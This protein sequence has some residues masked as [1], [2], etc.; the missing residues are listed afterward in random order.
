MHSL[1]RCGA[2]RWLVSGVSPRE[3]SPDYYPVLLFCVGTSDITRSSLRGI[4]K[5]YRILGV[6]VRDSRVQVVFSSVLLIKGK[7]VGRTS[8]IWH[9]NKWLQDWCHS[10]GF[11]YLDHGTH[12]EKPSLL[13]SI[14]QRREKHLR[15]EA[16]QACGEGFKLKLP[17]EEILNPFHSYQCNA[18]ASNRWLQ[19]LGKDHRS[20]REYLEW[21]LVTSGVP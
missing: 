13:G 7:V 11:D 6:V 15:S 9:I 2:Y 14:C 5:D 3:Y 18:S 17:Q 20:A 8:G 4:N 1:G 12:F 19:S 21:R 16:Y 10:R